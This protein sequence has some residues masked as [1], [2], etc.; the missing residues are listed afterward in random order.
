M[1][2]GDLQI[3]HA[4][5]TDS[6]VYQCVAHNPF[7]GTKKVA[8][9]YVSL[10]VRR[11]GPSSHRNS[12]PHLQLRFAVEP[13]SHV[14]PIVGS[15]ATLECVATGATPPNVTWSRI[16]GPLPQY[17]SIIVGGNLVIMTVRKSDEGTYTCKATSTDSAEHI[18]A[19]TVVSVHEP[20]R[21]IKPLQDINVTDGQEF[22]LDCG[23][24]GTPPPVVNW[25]FNGQIVNSNVMTSNG[26]TISGLNGEK[27]QVRSARD[28]KNYGIYQCFATNDLGSTYSM[29]RVRKQEKVDTVRTNTWNN[30]GDFWN[31]NDPYDY[32]D[33]PDQDQAEPLKY[34]VPSAPEISRLAE[35]SVMVRWMVPNN[36]GL[37]IGFFKVQYKESVKRSEWM[38]V[39]D[40]IPPHIHAYAVTGLKTNTKYKF[41]IAAV[42]SNQDNKDSP[43]S[44]AFYLSKT[45]VGV[46]PGAGPNIIDVESISPSAINLK[47]R[48]QEQDQVRIDGFFIH[49]RQASSAG[50]FSKITAL[51]AGT[52]A[53]IISHLLPDTSYEVKM[54]CFNEVGASEFSPLLSNKTWPSLDGGRSSTSR[55]DINGHKEV[56]PVSG[57]DD[58]T[59]YGVLAV[60]VIALILVVIVCV[61][62]CI[63]RHKQS[64]SHPNVVAKRRSQKPKER[65]PR[66]NSLHNLNHHSYKHDYGNPYGNYSKVNGI[67]GTISNGISNGIGLKSSVSN[68]FVFKDSTEDKHEIHIRINPLLD[69]GFEGR[70][71]TLSS[72][73]FL[74]NRSMSTRDIMRRTSSVSQHSLHNNH[75]ANNVAN[76]INNNT[77]N[78]HVNELESNGNGFVL[79]TI[80]RGRRGRNNFAEEAHPNSFSSQVKMHHRTSSFTRLNGTLERKRKSRTDLLAAVDSATL[81]RPECEPMLSNRCNGSTLPNGAANGHVIMQSSC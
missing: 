65:H 37:P 38:T 40:D 8:S 73:T 42:Y 66:A 35:D 67:N 2:S 4:R 27:L 31:S 52:R 44:D 23:V 64:V 19:S 68:G 25:V 20:P 21:I 5:Q 33:A 30:E 47:W 53:H 11:K 71:R 14:S 76:I 79:N 49:Y 41:R 59:L 6:G 36:G 26:L 77:G 72:T 50:D 43:P 54:Q 32:D 10:R 3:F 80:E 45:P 24:Q 18:S 56:D 28:P 39:E 69:E 16:D 51:G 74:G 58:T 22:A 62:L 70:S 75:V 60:A 12:R 55:P 81:G 46:K 13:K 78:N 29:A 61:I 15:N 48:Y 9:H 17:R 34:S 7:L 63:V 1:R 57:S